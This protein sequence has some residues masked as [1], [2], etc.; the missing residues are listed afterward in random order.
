M[1]DLYLSNGYLCVQRRSVCRIRAGAC[2]YARETRSKFIL[3][4]GSR[5]VWTGIKSF[6]VLVEHYIRTFKSPKATLVLHR[7]L[8]AWNWGAQH[9]KRELTRS[10]DRTQAGHCSDVM[11]RNPRP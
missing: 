10:F 7:E 4:E 5:E 1:Y 8:S 2:M 6:S 9:A 11:F 3:S